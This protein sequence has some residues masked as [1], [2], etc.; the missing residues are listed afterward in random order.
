MN[1]DDKFFMSA[2]IDEAKKA[3]SRG[4]VPVGALLVYGNEIL[5]S[6]SDKKVSDLFLC[7]ILSF[8]QNL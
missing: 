8:H 7:I 3:F 4:D 1:F 6:G 2:A 5:S